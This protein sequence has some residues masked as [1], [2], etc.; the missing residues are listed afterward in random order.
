MKTSELSSA[1]LNWAVAKCEGGTDFWYDTIATYWIT[2]DG[3]DRALR[4]G[5]AQSY[6][7]STDWSQGGPIIERERI[8]IDPYRDGWRAI[9]YMDKV[10]GKSIEQIREYGL[11]P[12]I[13]A[14][15]CY[16]S[17]KLGDEVAVPKEL[18]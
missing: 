18:E 11:T 14:M 6:L 3:K 5:W 9:R 16:V 1:A 8:E 13:A 17:S 4:S 15:R 12:L 7:P 2:L 10:R